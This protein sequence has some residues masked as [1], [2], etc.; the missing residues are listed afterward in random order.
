M[1]ANLILKVQRAGLLVVLF[2]ITTA[3]MSQA[4]PTISAAN[5]DMFPKLAPLKYDYNMFMFIHSHPNLLM[6][7][8]GSTQQSDTLVSQSILIRHT[9]SH[10]EKMTLPHIRIKPSRMNQSHDPLV[11][12]RDQIVRE[13][14]IKEGRPL[15]PLPPPFPMKNR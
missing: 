4:Q 10:T 6:M 2:C 7:P 8:V 3:A 9:A 12:L 15:P 13:R 11:G 1:E 5:A 14:R